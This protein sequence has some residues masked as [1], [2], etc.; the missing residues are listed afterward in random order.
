MKQLFRQSIVWVAG[1]H[2]PSEIELD[3]NVQ[4]FRLAY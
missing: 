2:L 1:H 4:G 3:P